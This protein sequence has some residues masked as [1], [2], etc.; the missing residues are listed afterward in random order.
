MAKAAI[1]Q[2]FDRALVGAAPTSLPEL[3]HDSP[4]FAW[5]HCNPASLLDMRAPNALAARPHAVPADP[6]SLAAL[7]GCIAGVLSGLRPD[8]GYRDI[9]RFSRS[10]V[11]LILRS[12]WSR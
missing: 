6:S 8:H 9:A 5:R 10:H 3:A 7:R 4:H 2:S 12:L 1:F 11:G